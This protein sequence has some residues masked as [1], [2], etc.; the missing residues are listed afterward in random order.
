MILLGLI[1]IWAGCVI[2]TTGESPRHRGD[3]ERK[4]WEI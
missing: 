2:L 3:Q 1:L 4:V